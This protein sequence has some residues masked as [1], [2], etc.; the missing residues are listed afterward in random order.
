[1]YASDGALM[2]EVWVQ[3]PGGRPLRQHS[4]QPAP[5]GHNQT[6][7]TRGQ[8]PPAPQQVKV[9]DTNGNQG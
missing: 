4:A 1:M 3:K 9:V 2:T 8:V 5:A 6:V 7:P